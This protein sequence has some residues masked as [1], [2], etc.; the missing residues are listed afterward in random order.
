MMGDSDIPYSERELIQRAIKL[1]KTP[2][3]SP[4]WALVKRI[5]GTGKTVSIAICTKYGFDP[6]KEVKI[7]PLPESQYAENLLQHGITGYQPIDASD[8]LFDTWDLVN[9]VTNNGKIRS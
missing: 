4:R 8:I 2:T 5:F 3:C 6:D 9:L 7:M 1:A